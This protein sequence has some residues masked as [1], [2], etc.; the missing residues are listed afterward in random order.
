MK[1]IKCGMTGSIRE[2]RGSA[3]LGREVR[4]DFTAKLTGSEGGLKDPQEGG[5]WTSTEGRSSRRH[6]G[7]RGR[8]TASGLVPL[9]C[10]RGRQ[11]VRAGEMLRRARSHGGPGTNFLSLADGRC[12]TI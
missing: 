10:G 8:E 9:S 11:C 3:A 4:K 7:G 1:N 2:G 6:G 5:L 12:D